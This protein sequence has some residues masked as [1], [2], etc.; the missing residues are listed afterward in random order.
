MIHRLLLGP[1]LAMFLSITMNC[2]KQEDVTM[3]AIECNTTLDSATVA[4]IAGLK[5]F[6]GHQSVGEN[7]LS[8]VRE[9]TAAYKQTSSIGIASLEGSA[10][11]FTPAIYHRN[12]GKNGDPRA[13]ID[14]FKVILS[15]NGKGQS[16]DVACMKLCYVDISPSTDIAGLFSGYSA[17]VDQI[18]AA[19]PTLVIVHVTTPL[20]VNSNSLKG[21]LRDLIKGN[22]NA[23]RCNYNDL[24][25]QKYGSVDPIFD[26]AALESTYP[27]GARCSFV[28]KKQTYYSLIP[29]LSDDG[30]HLNKTGAC[31]AAKEFLKTIEKA[32]T[33]NARR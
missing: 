14:D 1:L 25:R 12:I 13:K 2:S 18:K 24:L 21:K 8:G 31:I 17:I 6:F 20:T 22:E 30:G 16:F 29:Q 27:D 26:L 15:D 9:V 5:I 23:A 10:Q 3:P 32:V 33:R 11:I 28:Y 7:V 19:F 4:T